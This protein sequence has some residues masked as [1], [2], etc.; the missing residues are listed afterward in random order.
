MPAGGDEQ[1][2]QPPELEVLGAVAEVTATIG[3]SIRFEQ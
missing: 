3:G 2:Y 1:S